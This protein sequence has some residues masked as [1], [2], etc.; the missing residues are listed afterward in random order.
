MRNERQ[1]EFK[2]ERTKTYSLTSWVTWKNSLEIEWL[3]S[4]LPPMNTALVRL[5]LLWLRFQFE[6]Q[7]QTLAVAVHIQLYFVARIQRTK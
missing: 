3:R 6:N 4:L 1:F 7:F 2:F 5:S